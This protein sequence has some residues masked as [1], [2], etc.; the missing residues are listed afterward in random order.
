MGF[1]IFTKLQNARTPHIGPRRVQGTLEFKSTSAIR[2]LVK[3]YCPCSVTR[4]V[5]EEMMPRGETMRDRISTLG[6]TRVYMTTVSCDAAHTGA[7]LCCAL[8]GVVQCR[9]TLCTFAL[10]NRLTLAIKPS[11]QSPLTSGIS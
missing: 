8:R 10:L 4:F 9:W 3:L 7:V 6:T 2:G 11:S 1:E 5:R